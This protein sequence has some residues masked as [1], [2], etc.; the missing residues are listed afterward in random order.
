[1]SDAF[2]LTLPSH[3]NRNEFPQ[4]QSNHFKIRL[5]HPKRLEG[6]GWKVGLSSISLPDAIIELPKLMDA[7]EILFIMDWAVKFAPNTTRFGRAWNNP[8]DPDIGVD[9]MKSVIN[10]FERRVDSFGGPTFGAKYVMEDEKR[11]YIKF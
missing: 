4:N 2:Y 3:S 11:T 7:K 9:F 1:M 5:P 10:Y 6:S 8:R